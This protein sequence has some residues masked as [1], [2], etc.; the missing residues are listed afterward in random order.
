MTDQATP[1]AAPRAAEIVLDFWLGELD[2]N[3]LASSEKSKSWWKKSADFD[4]RIRES[5]ATDSANILAGRN[6]DWL[7]T[8]RGT[9]AA[10]IVLDQFSRNM[11][12]DR[13]EM[14]AG[15]SLAVS[16]AHDAIKKGFDKDLP[17]DARVFLYMPF[18]HAEE[19][20]LQDRC[21]ELFAAMKDDVGEAAQG[22]IASNHKFAVQHRDIVAKWGRFPHRNEIVGREST[23]EEV[24]FLKSPG[25]SF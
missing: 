2:E 25:S 18:M 12:R 9:L 22:R 17:T 14:Y 4:R 19:L 7:E 23:P 6:D 1:K 8:P 13:P 10:V 21:V 3:G 20:A 24:E 16:L 11:Y 15:D 5:F